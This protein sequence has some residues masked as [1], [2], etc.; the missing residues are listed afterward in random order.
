MTSDLTCCEH[1]TTCNQGL[2]QTKPVPGPV[3]EQIYG[4]G[5][6]PT[7]AREVPPTL[8]QIIESHRAVCMATAGQIA[9]LEAIL[10]EYIDGLLDPER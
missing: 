3:F 2:S 6:R 1:G 5:G 9:D 10:T 8:A 7:G 4:P